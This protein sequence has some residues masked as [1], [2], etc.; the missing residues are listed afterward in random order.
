MNNLGYG[1]NKVNAEI[2]NLEKARNEK[3]REHGNFLDD[4]VDKMLTETDDL[5]RRIEGLKNNYEVEIG[6]M[7]DQIADKS[8]EVAR[9]S[10]GLFW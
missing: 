6:R 10:K 7:K 8:Q 3:I 4:F 2:G 9:L 1:L 5:N